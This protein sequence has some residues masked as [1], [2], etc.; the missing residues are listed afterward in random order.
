M[1]IDIMHG[2]FIGMM[3]KLCELW[4]D[5][6]YHG[7][8]FSISASVDIVDERLKNLKPPSFFPCKPR[9]IKKEFALYK[10]K[11]FKVFMFYYSL[12]VLNGILPVEYWTHYCKLVSAIAI[13]SQE[14]VSPTQLAAADSLLHAYVSVF[15]ILYGLRFMTMNVHQ[16]LH[17]KMVVENLGNLW[18]YS[19]FFYESLNGVIARLVHGTRYAGLQICS[20]SSIFLKLPVMID[21]LND[22]RRVKDFCLRLQ[23]AGKPLLKI[24]E[25]IDHVT[26]VVGNY[27]NCNVIPLDVREAL[28]INCNIVGGYY[29]YFFRLK[30]YGVVY[31]S[32]SYVRS[33]QRLS[34]Y[35]EI[36]SNGVPLLCKINSFIKWSSCEHDFG[37]CEDCDKKFLCIVTVYEKNAWEMHFDNND[38][39]AVVFY[40]NKVTPTNQIC[41]FP[42]EL[43]QCMCVY[44]MVGDSE[45][46][47]VPVNTLEIE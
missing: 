38:H 15:Q 14:S 33:K 16:L 44:M 29:K 37:G 27:S 41:A 20:S 18:V 46:V 31:S 4:F 32:A 9:S 10:A 43:I 13:L 42:V 35:A 5:S 24:T 36:L 7:L 19:C 26:Q 21:S 8:P 1:G 47:A 45:Y 28:R 12:V 30:K 3:K 23:R 40:L 2:V 22:E 25:I 6:K 11:D 34:C 39:N 17:L